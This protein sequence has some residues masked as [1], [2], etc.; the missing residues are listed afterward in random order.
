MWGAADQ[1]ANGIG[2][3]APLRD[4]L[5]PCQIKCVEHLQR[6]NAALIDVGMPFEDRK[7]QLSK[8]AGDFKLPSLPKVAMEVRA[9]LRNDDSTNQQ[10]FEGL[11]ILLAFRLCRYQ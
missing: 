1:S 3:D 9:L 2:Q 10:A 6:T 11:A 8:M 4:Y 7:A 5:T